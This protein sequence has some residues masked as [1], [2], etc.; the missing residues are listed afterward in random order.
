MPGGQITAEDGTSIAAPIV[1][2]IAAMIRAFF[3]RLTAPEV[4][5]LLFK[6]A[7]QGEVPIIDALAACQ[8]ALQK[9]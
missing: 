8:A 1:A 5:E 2:G 9:K 7:R 4:V 6:T 3:P